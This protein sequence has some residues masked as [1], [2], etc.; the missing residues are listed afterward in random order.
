MKQQL[1]LYSDI[2][3]RHSWDWS[4]E[5]AAPVWSQHRH[6]EVQTAWRKRA[7]NSW[8]DREQQLPVDIFFY[9][10]YIDTTNTVFFFHKTSVWTQCID[11][12]KPTLN[13]H[14]WTLPEC[15]AESMV[16]NRC[17]NNAWR[18][19]Q[20]C[21]ES[22]GQQYSPHGCLLC[23]AFCVP[24]MQPELMSKQGNSFPRKIQ[25]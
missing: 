15:F 7:L 1:L 12:T 8:N 17:R 9:I 16:R 23:R 25:I 14:Q 2:F 13:T 24:L 21:E 5:S 18:A 19:K 22:R 11:T 3:H 10:Y 6:K 4:L 20:C